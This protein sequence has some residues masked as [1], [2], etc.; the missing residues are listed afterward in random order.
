MVV[1]RLFGAE[2]LAAL[3]ARERLDAQVAGLV[4]PQAE[5]AVEGDVTPRAGVLLRPAVYDDLVVRL[6]DLRAGTR[7][8]GLDGRR[9]TL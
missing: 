2:R 5:A 1:E 7:L 8:G 9:G 6:L 4:A 3:F